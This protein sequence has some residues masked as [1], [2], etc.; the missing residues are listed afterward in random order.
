MN[1]FFKPKVAIVA[2][3]VAFSATLFSF[4]SVKTT[5]KSLGNAYAKKINTANSQKISA[6]PQLTSVIRAVA[7]ATRAS[8]NAMLEEIGYLLMLT[9]GNYQPTN[10][11]QSVEELKKSKIKNLD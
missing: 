10:N 1:K 8:S 11:D 9:A 6:Q 3:A 7:A 4:S 2:C 5:E